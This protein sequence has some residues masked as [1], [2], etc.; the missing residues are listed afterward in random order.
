MAKSQSFFSDYR[1]ALLFFLSN[2]VII[3]R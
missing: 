1:F 3:V 2:L